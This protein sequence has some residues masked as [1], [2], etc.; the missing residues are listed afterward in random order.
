MQ[1]SFSAVLQKMNSSVYGFAIPVPKKVGD[2]YKKA[3]IKRLVVTYNGKEKA[4]CA[5]MPG[6][7]K[8][9]WLVINKQI[10]TKL[11]LDIGSKV[12]VIVEADT[13]KYGMPLPPEMEELLL[14]DPEGDIIFHKLTAGK[15]R[16][17]LYIIGKPK[18][19]D[20]RLKKAV[21]ILEYLKMV[22]G[23]LD[24]PEMN[25]YIKNFKI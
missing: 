9:Y 21:A 23:K 22:N 3:D 16:S 10:R 17:L 12:D 18:T 2:G 24:F 19:S 13:S 5:F 14:Q 7:E 20:T 4:N 6:M 8:G 11:K 25:E 1:Y 15:Q